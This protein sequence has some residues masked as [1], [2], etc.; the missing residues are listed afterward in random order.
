MCFSAKSLPYVG[1]IVDA[2]GIR[3]DSKKLQAI[4][5]YPQPESPTEVRRLLGMVN[6]LAKFVP[7]LYDET[8]PLS[9]HVMVWAPSCLGWTA[10]KRTTSKGRSG[11]SQLK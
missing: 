2:D 11:A 7:N 3:P 6:Q 1:L 5:D 8:G 9:R 4:L 10:L